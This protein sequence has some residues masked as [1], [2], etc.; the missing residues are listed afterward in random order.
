M[1]NK[2]N[3]TMKNVRQVIMKALMVL[4]CVI[5]LM[6]TGTISAQAATLNDT[7]VHFY[8]GKTSN[9]VLDSN[10]FMLRRKAILDGH[11]N[12]STITESAV[13]KVGTT[14]GSMLNTYTYKN[15]SNGFSMTVNAK[16]I[17]S[18]KS[19]SYKK[20]SNPVS[21]KKKLQSELKAHPEGVV[22]YIFNRSSTK[23]VWQH[24]VLLTKI[25][26]DKF[27]CLDPGLKNGKEI[28][29]TKSVIANS[30]HARTTSIHEILKYSIKVWYIKTDRNTKIG[31]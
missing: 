14:K 30:K 11:D 31:R 17:Y 25:D 3:S 9:C 18:M 10:V 7:S 2:M 16:T 26:G 21:V 4:I 1:S 6:Q 8:Q 23:T 5:T 13:S 15:T 24:A 20:N 29:L 19:N 28:L 27:Y 22:L 12:W